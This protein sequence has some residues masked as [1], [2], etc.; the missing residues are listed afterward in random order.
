M[1]NNLTSIFYGMLLPFH[2]NGICF[3]CENLR[4]CNIRQRGR[5]GI[6]SCSLLAVQGE[7]PLR[8]SSSCAS[9]MPAL[10]I[11]CKEEAF[12]I[13]W[14]FECVLIKISKR[15]CTILFIGPTHPSYVGRDAF[16]PRGRMTIRGA[17]IKGQKY[18]TVHKNK[19]KKPNTSVSI[20]ALS[21]LLRG[22][23]K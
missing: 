11:Q 12:L 19:R 23:W 4:F 16:R 21:D 6:V 5:G 9:W 14:L 13:F 1:K 10:S 18:C 8:F 22:H 7:M 15:V 17:F 2:L 20:V 3:A